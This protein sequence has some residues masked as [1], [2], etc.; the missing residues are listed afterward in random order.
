MTNQDGL[1]VWQGTTYRVAVPRTR[2]P[3]VNTPLLPLDSGGG[4]ERFWISSFSRDG[5]CLG[6]LIT[7]WGRERSV[8]FDPDQHGCYSAIQTDEHTL[9]LCGHL[10]RLVRLDLRTLAF[11]VFPTGAPPALVFQGMPFDAATGRLF[12]MAVCDGEA[13]AFT[14]DTRA[15]RTVRMHR[16]FTPLHYMRVSVPNG[17]GTWSIVAHVPDV[18][19]LRWDPAGETVETVMT[20]LDAP[21]ERTLRLV[22]DDA[23]RPYVPTQGWYDPRRG[24][25]DSSGPSPE[26]E[27]TWFARR[28]DTVY[29]T[30]SGGDRL[31]VGC[32]NLADGSVGD[33]GVVPDARPFN[34]AVTASG[35]LVAVDL[36]GV[37]SRQ[38]LPLAGPAEKRVELA[39]DVVNHT[40][41][42]CRINDRLLLGTP[43]ISQRFWVADIHTGHGADKGRAAGGSGEILAVWRAAGKAYMA[44]YAGG[45]LMAYDPDGTPLGY[46]A[47]PRVVASPPRAMRP[48]AQAQDD[49]HLYYSCSAPYGHLG[50]TLTA[51]DTRSGRAAYAVDPIGRQAIC[52]LYR[53]RGR[54]VLLAG[55]TPHADC[56]SRPAARER[57]VLA[58]VDAATLAVRTVVDAPTGS[59]TV[60][61]VGPVDDRRVLCLTQE[62]YNL[63]DDRD[64]RWFL[65]EADTLSLPGGNATA[66][67]P[68]GVRHVAYAGVPG[69]FVLQIGRR[70]E[71]WAFA[72][73]V[74]PHATAILA[75]NF[76]GYDVVVQDDSV[77]LLDIETIT[78]LEGSLRP[79]DL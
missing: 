67:L 50:C 54:G 25:F 3:F 79:R 31:T 23:G 6:V 70:V 44:A 1:P 60:R 61:I 48:I 43:F 16:D 53:H 49:R 36:Y 40:D 42:V 27:M 72:A 20:G 65:A 46:P 11:E 13:V 47:N 69:R 35:R 21:T 77:Y 26:R 74:E 63:V 57:S 8:E 33:V 19:I 37:F 34:V 22:C 38:L 12:A 58:V 4:E 9:W 66:P 52:S 73:D 7:E 45:E 75:E 10:D 15:C 24:T 28:G 18:G 76:H 14:Y 59:Q 5:G 71:R 78:I 29:G 41:R 64:A 39:T 62:C 56:R 32:W 51:Y 68:D 55:T 2:A 30:D 17:D